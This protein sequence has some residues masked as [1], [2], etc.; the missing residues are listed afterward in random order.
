MKKYLMTGMAAVALCGMMTG[1][2]N[3]MDNALTPEESITKIYEDAFIQRFGQPA[4]DLDWGFHNV[5]EASQARSRGS[6]PNGNLWE[7]E[8]WNVPPELTSGQKE[9]VYKYFQSH[10]PIGYSDPGWSNFWIQQVYKGG[11]DATNSYSKTKEEYQS[12]NGGWVVGSNHMDHLAAVGDGKFDHIY[13]FNN[14]NC[15]DWGGRMLMTNSTTKSFGYYNSDGSLGHT[16]YTGLVSWT[17]IEAWGEANG[18]GSSLNDGW[19]RSFMGFD[20]EQVVGDDI[21]AGYAKYTC[22]AFDG[23]IW[24]GTNVIKVIDGYDSNWQPIYKEG[25]EYMTYKGKP[26]YYLTSETNQYCG[27]LSKKG[28][29]DVVIEKDGHKCVDMVKINQYLADGYLPVAGSDMKDWVKVQGGADGYYSDWIVTLCEAKK[30][31]D[32]DNPDNPDDPDNPDTPE[33]PDI[34]TNAVVR[35]IAEDLTVD[36]H[37]DF[38]FNDVV[39]DV[40]PNGDGT[41]TIILRAAGGTLPLYVAGHEVHQEFAKAYPNKGITT[42]TMINTRGFTVDPVSFTISGSYDRATSINIPIT[43]TKN[44]TSVT[45]TANKGKTAS[46]VAVGTDYQWCNERQ[47]IDNKYHKRNGYRLFTGYVRGEVGDNWYK[48][49]ND[50]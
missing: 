4:D 12:A 47:D 22:P 46:K 37:S 3:E 38:D 31:G 32:P 24:D 20:F 42:M 9:R 40:A 8:G 34:P 23:Y 14:G 16:D 33:T 10:T 1:C 27:T 19:N 44:G 13:N 18:V 15:T 21:Y 5:E 43:V 17:V 45:L 48:L 28:E 36:E 29:S 50:N 26:V 7:E 2:S 49:V 25:Y 39:F 6:Y 11:T 30:D 41:T 35:I